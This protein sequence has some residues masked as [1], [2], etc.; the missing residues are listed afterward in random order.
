MLEAV[1]T[2][3]NRFH[4]GRFDYTYEHGIYSD[5]YRYEGRPFGAAFDNDSDSL[6]LIGE[7]FQDN[8]QQLSWTISHI[9]LNTDNSNRAGPGGNVFGANK[10]SLIHARASYG[11][12]FAKTWKVTLGGE[13]HNHHLTLGTEDISSGVFAKIELK[14]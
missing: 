12:P 1:T 14:L 2:V 4:G 5:G 6:S 11:I 8:G 9:N 3:S 13:L 10:T 7:H